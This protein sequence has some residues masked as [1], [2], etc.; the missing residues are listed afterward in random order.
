MSARPSFIPIRS[1]QFADEAQ[2]DQLRELIADIDAGRVKM[3]VIL[4]GNPVYN[5]PADLKLNVERMNKVPL[6]VHL[7]S[8]VDE[9]AEHLPLARCRKS[10][11]SKRGATRRAYDGTVTI[12][13]PLIEPLYDGHSAHEVVQLFFKENFDKKDYDIVKEYLADAERIRTDSSRPPLL[14]RKHASAPDSAA[15]NFGSSAAKPVG[16]G[17]H[18]GNRPRQAAPAAEH[19]DTGSRSNGRRSRRL[20]RQRRLRPHR[21]TSKIAGER[22]STT[23]WSRTRRSRRRR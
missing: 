19:A 11:I 20:Q 13:Q 6:R 8:H 14:P 21:R 2:I 5:T 22:S 4:G 23:V 12:V 18:T 10:I 15:G 7:G 16:C 3:L 1:T 9:T 17:Q